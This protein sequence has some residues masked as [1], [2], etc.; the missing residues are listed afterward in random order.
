MQWTGA[1]SSV[2]AI[3]KPC[4]RPTLRHQTYLK[5]FEAEGDETTPVDPARV[6]LAMTCL[7]RIDDLEYRHKLEFKVSA[8]DLKHSD[9]LTSRSLGNFK[10][11]LQEHNGEY[12]SSHLNHLREI[13]QIAHILQTHIKLIDCSALCAQKSFEHESVVIEDLIDGAQEGCEVGAGLLQCL[14]PTLQS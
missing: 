5:H 3:L 8:R 14:S 11:K 7:R 12:V 4:G 10:L 13:S 2:R 1:G 6:D 9:L